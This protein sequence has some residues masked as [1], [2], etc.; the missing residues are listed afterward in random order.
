MNHSCSLDRIYLLVGRRAL[1]TAEEIVECVQETSSMGMSFHRVR[2]VLVLR[3]LRGVGRT[4]GRNGGCG[5]RWIRR[6]KD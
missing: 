3:R 2:L 5:E 1:S 4:K 6:V